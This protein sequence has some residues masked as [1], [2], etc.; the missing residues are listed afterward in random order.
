MKKYQN[1]NNKPR[2]PFN[3]PQEKEFKGTSI[4]VYNGDVNGAI[5]KLKKVLEMD[6]RQKEL[7]KREFY[8]K[9]SVKRKRTKD[10]AKKRHQKDV[11]RGLI[12]GDMSVTRPTGVSFMKSK[13][14]RRKYQDLENLIKQARR[15]RGHYQ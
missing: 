12:S 6:N 7:A 3:K 1:R 9:P 10:S 15:R 5:R 13:R 8:E 2:R 4:S 14:K 11:L